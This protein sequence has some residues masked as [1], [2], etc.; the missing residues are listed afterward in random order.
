MKVAPSFSVGARV[1]LHT[2]RGVKLGVYT[3]V[4]K[5]FRDGQFLTKATEKRRFASVDKQRYAVFNDA[6]EVDFYCLPD[7]TA[8]TKRLSAIYNRDFRKMLAAK[9]KQGGQG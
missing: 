7:T 3:T 9:R 6:G 8:L 4:T 5:T 1:W 2:P